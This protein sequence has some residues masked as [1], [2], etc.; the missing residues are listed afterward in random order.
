MADFC[1]GAGEGNRTLV[2]SLEGFGG[3]RFSA[4]YP[5]LNAHEISAYMAVFCDLV[6]NLTAVLPPHKKPRPLIRANGATQRTRSVRYE[7]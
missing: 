3:S 1:G 5:T 6:L 2:V 7:Y 4:I